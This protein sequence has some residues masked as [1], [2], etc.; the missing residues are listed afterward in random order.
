MGLILVREFP[1]T[2]GS[3][4]LFSQNVGTVRTGP[5]GSR[6]RPCLQQGLVC[7]ACAPHIQAE[8]MKVGRVV[9]NTGFCLP[10]RIFFGRLWA[11]CLLPLRLDTSWNLKLAIFF[12]FKKACIQQAPNPPSLEFFFFFFETGF[13]C[14]ALADLELTL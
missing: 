4:L 10:C 8:E 14:V 12:F 3:C 13:L 7:Y 6:S 2:L 1:L 9:S 5:L 11:L